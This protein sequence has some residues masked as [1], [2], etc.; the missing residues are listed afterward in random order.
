MDLLNDT[1]RHLERL[2]GFAT[3]A[4]AENAAVN[5]YVAEVLSA[6]GARVAHV[7]A[8]PGGLDGLVASIGPDVPGGIG[9][10]GHSDVVPV[11]GQAW[12]GD[13]FAMRRENGRIIGRGACDM[14]G[15]D[16]C[17]IA[18]TCA[19]AKREL[20]RPVH[21]FLSGDEE[22]HLLSAPALIDH[23]RAHLPPLRG[24]VVGEP[25]GCIPVDRHEASA[26]LD[27]TCRGRPMHASIAH[28]AVSATALAARLITW[29][30]EETARNAAAA[31]EGAFD[32]NYATHTVGM[33]GGGNAFNI[34]AETC[35]FTWDV[36][37]MPGQALAEVQGRLEAYAQDL[38]KPARQIA[39][40]ADIVVT[41]REWFPGLSGLADGP[42]REEIAAV[43]GQTDFAV[44]PYGT[45]A[46]MFHEAGFDAVVWGPGDIAQAHTADEF[47]E[48]AQIA[49][50]LERAE[51]LLV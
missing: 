17:A 48:E 35:K 36:R 38:L 21:L 9:L 33:I 32:P 37:L 7:P 15:F 4:G 47:I 3:V 39:P 26:T 23:A 18:L 28:R 24:V 42:F 50:Y 16:A 44:V 49:R 20:S 43:S 13:P 34:V 51:A 22:T 41:L 46:G 19:A 6:A 31:T 5:S 11:E 29:L 14:K 40:E 27:V 30:E 2:I 8:R 1:L 10:S 25:T 45:E 12:S